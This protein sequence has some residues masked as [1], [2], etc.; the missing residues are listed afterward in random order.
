[1]SMSRLNK[2]LLVCCCW[3]SLALSG[4]AQN[5]EPPTDNPSTNKKAAKELRT[6]SDAD[7]VDASAQPPRNDAPL[8]VEQFNNIPYPLI[9]VFGGMQLNQHSAGFSNLPGVPSCCPGYESGSGAGVA[10]GGMFQLP[11]TETIALQMRASFTSLGGEIVEPESFE[12]LNENTDETQTATFE[13]RLESSINVLA[14]E[15]SALWYPI[16]RPLALRLGANL[17]FVISDSYS[18]QEV[19]VTP[20][21]ATFSNGD[22][23]RNAS[24]GAI[25]N[26]QS[27]YAGVT[28][29]VGY[30]L[31]LA[32]FLR[33]TPEISYTYNVTN[34]VDGI[35]WNVNA[36]R[37]GAG[38]SYAFFPS[39]PPPPPPP[40]APE[41]EPK[42]IPEPEPLEP[43]PPPVL[44][45]DISIGKIFK[46]GAETDDMSLTVEETEYREV[47]PLLPIVYFPAGESELK[48]TR[49]NRITPDSAETFRES[50]LPNKTLECYYHTLNIIGR[51][52]LENPEA[53]ISLKGVINPR[54]GRG[55]PAELAQERAEEVRKYFTDVWNISD[56]RIS[57]ST[58]PS[59]KVT[60]NSLN[61]VVEEERSVVISTDS[62]EVLRPVVITRSRRGID[63]TSMEF[64]PSVVSEAGLESLEIEIRQ[65][66]H[67]VAALYDTTSGLIRWEPEADAFT[68]EE[69]PLTI[70][71]K[72]RD[73]QG[74]SDSVATS[75]PVR[76][77]TIQ[78]KKLNN[79]KDRIIEKYSLIL[80]EFDD[81]ELDVRNRRILDE[82]ASR[83][84]PNS[85]VLIQGF[86]DRTGTEEYNERLARD[87]SRKIVQYLEDRLEIE[88]DNI[89]WE[90]V[91]K[92]RALYDNDLTEG[93]AYSRTVV[94]SIETPI[95]R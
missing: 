79:Q 57:L 53:K 73:I 48:Q 59:D 10:F 94:I 31:P 20:E 15:P 1:M 26:A 7:S 18:E 74:Q 44:A 16:D 22:V 68:N 77:L 51:R 56:D 37:F 34:V 35:D 43:P 71:L 92:K 63:V 42:P 47:L 36:L 58:A 95:K 3:F 9:G 85:T 62:Y 90:A 12:I 67:F 2:A 93:R 33:L 49:L 52:L 4:Q 61:E 32:A 6:A 66:E 25:P 40:P 50:D 30:D 39:P 83:I 64:L 45:T 86:T 76:Q 87:R 24:D 89:R 5:A 69:T 54:E 21:A 46:N 84:Q 65:G 78:D 27:L 72:V 28:L 17:G 23:V 13:H 55:N 38:V 14:L 8:H 41:P 82:V 80:F 70:A 91:G 11:A 29:G 88:H 75:V 81:H 60:P 19:L